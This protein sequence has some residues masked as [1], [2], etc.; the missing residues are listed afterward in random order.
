[1]RQNRFFQKDY[2]YH[3]INRGNNQDI[4]LFKRDYKRFTSKLEYYSKK[5]LISIVAY[6]LIP[7]HIHLLVKQGSE[8]TVS[9]FMQSLTTSYAAYFNN[10]HHRTGH[11]FQ[12]RFKHIVVET[13]GYL[14]HL[15]R[16]IHLNPSSARLVSKPEN[17][18]WSSYRCYLDLE[19]TNFINKKPILDYFSIKDK[20]M[21]YREFV[22]SRIDYQKEISIQKLFLE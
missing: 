3:L 6:A 13:D 15:S 19:E 16:Y 5:F 12:G 20:V 14:V 10:K 17:Y 1:M 21:D 7:N 2:Y 8:G 18:P 22:D 9:K 4:F 11:L